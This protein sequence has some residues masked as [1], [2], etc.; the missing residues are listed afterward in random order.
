M[1]YGYARIST[2]KQDIDRQIRNIMAMEPSA[3]IYQEV[4]TGTK[5]TGRK[6]LKKLLDRVD[7][8]DTIIFDSVSRMSRNAEEG[9]E[10]YKELYDNGVNLIYINEPYINTSV[11]RDAT[12]TMV[13]M[14]GTNVDVILEG[15]NKYL[16]ILAEQQIRIAFEQAQKERDDLSERTKQGI[17]TARNKGKQIGRMPGAIV[18]TKKAEN[19]K[20]KIMKL[21]KAFGGGNTDKELIAM[22][23][24]DKN[25]YY[26]Y[27]KELL[28][29]K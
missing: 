11:Y 10:M 19:S 28:A 18:R 15:V 13:P 17:E 5:R 16:L 2:A 4:F 29:A 22:L 27:K 24:I 12:K 26:K 21:S 9:F 8:G 3:K 23:G 1:I 25:T 20:K 7:S 14:T 6:E